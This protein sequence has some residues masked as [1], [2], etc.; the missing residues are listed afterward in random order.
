M[1]TSRRASFYSSSS[2]TV[3][4]TFH[5]DRSTP[6]PKPNSTE[7]PIQF[8]PK[9]AQSRSQSNSATKIQSA[10]RAHAIRTLYK[11]ISAVSSEADH[12]QRLIQRQETVDAIR[13]NEREKLRMNEA[14]MGLLL[15][16]DSV[17]GFNPTVREARRKVSR[18]I[19]ALQ[20]IL[21]AVSEAKTVYDDDCYE[22]GFV[23]SWDDVVAKMEEEVCRE[24]GGDEME[25]F[26]AE[27]LGFRCLQRFLSGP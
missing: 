26:C 5:N 21:D 14:L 3:T 27:H 16:L 2:T 8:S 10:Y 18:R 19:V 15:K 17:P 12:L 25:R 11:K 7:I 13:S 24:R 20:E 1:K 23:R 9:T 6:P 22:Y 4:Y